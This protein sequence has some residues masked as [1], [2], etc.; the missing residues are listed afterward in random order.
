MAERLLLLA[1]DGAR[2]AVLLDVLRVHHDRLLVDLHGRRR[3]AKEEMILHW[4]GLLRLLLAIGARRL[5]LCCLWARRLLKK[6]VAAQVQIL[7]PTLAYLVAAVTERGAC[8]GAGAT[9]PLLL[10]V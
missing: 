10:L 3:S 8:G 2:R 9:Y 5:I 1:L 4:G 7:L 6:L